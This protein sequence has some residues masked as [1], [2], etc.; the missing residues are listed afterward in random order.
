LFSEAS[1]RAVI[2]ICLNDPA[3][4]WQTFEKLKPIHFQTPR[5]ARIWDAMCRMA[6][7][8]KPIRQ[9]WIPM[10]IQNDSGETTPISVFVAVLMNDAPP[11]GE[12]DAYVDT[13][14]HLANKRALLESLDKARSE[15]LRLDVGTP[16]ESMKDIG[17]KEISNAFA[18]DTDEDMMDYHQWGARVYANAKASVEKEEDGGYGLSTG[19]KAVEEVIGRLLPGKLIVLAGISSG[20]KSA[21]ARQI[22]ESASADAAA[23]GLGHGYMASL[24]RSG[25]EYA[26]RGI[27]PQTGISADRIE[28]GSANKGEVDA[29]RVAAANLRKF[30]IVI[31]S[32]PR[33]TLEN[34]RARALKVKNTKGLSI[35]A[36]DH[37]LLIRAAGKNVSMFDLVSEATIECKNM[38]KEFGIPVILLSQLNE[39]KIL[40]SPSGW[41]NSSH[42]FGGQTIVQNADNV[43]FVH[44]PEMIWAK[45]EPAQSDKEKH[46]KWVEKMDYYKGRAWVYNNKR[47]SGAPNTKHELLFNGPTM[48]FGDI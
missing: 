2:G 14:L 20:G 13:V 28:S 4:F 35:M 9:H 10:M 17:I 40:E 48:T 47:R 38:A 46:T 34:I 26:A 19:L 8:K 16:A 5:L 25:M 45:K 15:I 1:E 42:L 43:F 18:N 32:R 22:M 36:I 27:S 29:I 6:E 11:P 7:A 33:L 12:A 31:D 24:E 30:P 39:S 37:L 41:P 3:V 23:R 44:R 21:L